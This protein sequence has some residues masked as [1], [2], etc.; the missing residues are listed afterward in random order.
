VIVVNTDVRAEADAPL[1]RDVRLLGA[2]LGKVIAEQEGDEL[3]EAEE[4]IRLRARDAR[5]TGDVDAVRDLVRTLSPGE[6]AKVLRAFGLYFQ[7][8]NIAEQHHRLRRRRQYAAEDQQAPRESLADAFERLSDIDENELRAR[9][10]RLSLELVLTAHPTEATRRT[11]LLAH[12][13]VAE[14]L[15]ALDAAASSS[16]EAHIESE[17]GEQIT[18]LWQTDEVRHGR[19]RVTDEIRH[20]LWFFEH[21]LP[22]AAERLLAEYRARLPDAPSPFS[23]GTW[24]GGDMDGNPAAGAETIREALSRARE[25]ALGRYRSDVREL[26]VA[27]AMH[28]SLVKVS[29]ELDESI[30]RDERELPEYAGTIGRRSELEPYRRKL[31]F[32]WWRL[33]NDGY[34]RPAEL[35]ADLD[36]LGRS[37]TA[38]RG[39]RIAA[40]RLAALRRRVEIFGF[41]LAKLDVR[42]HASE[43]RE[44]TARTR[45]ALVAA[46]DV[47]RR[48]GPEA[49]D[50][51]IVSGTTSAADV[52]AVLDLSDEPLSVVP[53][54]ETISDLGRAPAVVREL[55][56]DPRFAQR[57]EDRDR[58][59]E[60]M[61]GYSDS[62]KDG[63]F[64]AA[65]WAIYRAQEELVEVAREAEVELTIFHG[66]GGSPGRGG[67]PTH[68]AILAQPAG[69]PPGRLKLTE[70]GETISFK[71][72]LPGLAHRNL[73]AALAGTLLAAF[74]EVSA[75]APTQEERTA[76]DNLAEL[77]ERRY[78]AFVHEEPLFVDFFRAFTPVDELALLEI[79]S[80]PT[81]RPESA[82]FL[83]SLRA[84]PWVFAWT[85]N[86]TILPAWFGSGTALGSLVE[87]GQVAALRRLY[88]RLPFFRSLVDTL[89]MTL[90]KSSLEI[91]SQYVE[92]VPAEL[93]P[94]RLYAEIA[95]EHERT[96]DA[97]L[98][99]L[100]SRTLLERQPVL[101]RSI[102]LRNPYV[103]PMNAIQVELLRRF[104]SGDE[105]ARL[106]LMRSI[107]GIAA[108]LRNTG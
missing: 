70:Q 43:L 80:R 87:G 63:G 72:G 107:A 7:L 67:G 83:G 102:Q 73:E 13:R 58:R 78:R 64:L 10:S 65:Q 49:L 88:A 62:G 61:V 96:V 90:A 19:P 4:R 16:E 41:P 79:G 11:Y 54:F 20:G 86:R 94:E 18:I 17:L 60:V 38:N 27:L 34:D 42:L 103:D 23:F 77:A 105:N 6:Q 52:L 8:A 57:V 48:H 46:A 15:A 85:Q 50:T 5:G 81:R 108:A 104:R 33:G 44:P 68:A 32:V 76:L 24:I 21:S 66:R 40:G 45:D 100:E 28:R 55:L 97:V 82:D 98:Q 1:R 37:L 14:L 71:Y 56:A 30:G 22:D 25:L 3:L 106:P 29:R 84:I 101:R 53:L 2:V 95:S 91:A 12:L 35:L 47:R 92:L 99:T 89:E 36:V 59:L 75:H 93:E 51:V 39:T 69:H 26:A 31:S 9:V 74:P